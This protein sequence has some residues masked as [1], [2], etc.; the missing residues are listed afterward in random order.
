MQDND[1]DALLKG[2]EKAAW[3]FLKKSENF[4]S[5]YK[6][7]TGYLLKIFFHHLEEWDGTCLLNCTYFTVM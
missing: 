1:F 4:L 5:K 6:T 7:T 2:K 3:M